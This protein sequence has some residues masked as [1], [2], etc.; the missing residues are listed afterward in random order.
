MIRRM[1]KKDITNAVQML[2]ETFAKEPWNEEWP[3]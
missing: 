2:R 1:E 3:L